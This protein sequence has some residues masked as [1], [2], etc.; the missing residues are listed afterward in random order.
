LC[1]S[2]S[3]DVTV[4]RSLRTKRDPGSRAQGPEG[5][6]V[7]EDRVV[8]HGDEP[9]DGVQGGDAVEGLQGVV[10]AHPEPVADHPQGGEASQG[11]ERRIVLDLQVAADGLEAL[12]AG[13][14]HQGVVP[15]DAEVAAH[16]SQAGRGPQ[17]DP[18]HVL[19]RDLAEHVDGVVFGTQRGDPVGVEV[20]RHG[21]VPRLARPV[22][23]VPELRGRG[24]GLDLD[25][26]G[27][28]GVGGGA[29]G[30]EEGEQE[31]DSHG[32]TP[33]GRA[34]CAPLAAGIGAGS[35]RPSPRSVSV[36]AGS[37]ESPHRRGRGGELSRH[38]DRRVRGLTTDL[39][40]EELRPYFL[41]DEDVSIG[42]LR[43]VL[44][45]P[46]DPRRARLMGKM[47]REAR[48]VDVWQFVTPHD[49]EQSLASLG[50]RLGRRRAFW[51]FLIDG[52]REDGLLG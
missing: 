28:V 26:R 13:E 21:G 43:A 51:E 52:W 33:V 15:E 11:D 45:S 44:R 29:R 39:T 38:Y 25:G 42:E 40:K 6:E 34:L 8:A 4:G 49:V 7:G 23:V 31:D 30:R 12:Q 5:V 19:D 50:R 2:P 18:V 3:K 46:Q 22:F 27:R 47:L 20:A 16:G 10:E 36:C 32:T 48:D 35:T 9:A 41:W 14:V 24:V 1:S 37:I 17:I